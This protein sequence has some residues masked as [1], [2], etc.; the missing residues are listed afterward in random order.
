[1]TGP[2]LRVTEDQ[3][4]EGFEIITDRALDIAD[5]SVAGSA[6]DG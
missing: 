3:L 2:P 4:T 1:M 5:R 6:P